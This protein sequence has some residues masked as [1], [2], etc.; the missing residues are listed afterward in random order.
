[1]IS[2]RACIFYATLLLIV[3]ATA[4]AQTPIRIAAQ[5][6]D[7][8]F[9]PLLTAVYREMGFDAQI[10]VLP[11]ARALSAT[12]AGQFDAEVGRIP[13][14]SPS[15]PDLAYTQEPLLKVQLVAVTLKG[16]PIGIQSKADLEK[17][18]VG[19][20]NGMSVSEYYVKKESLTANSVASHEQLAKMLEIGRLDVVLMGTAF[21]QSPVFAVAETKWVIDEFNVFH[22]FHKR[23]RDLI[24][25]FDAQLRRTKQDGRYEQLLTRP[26]SHRV[27]GNA[28]R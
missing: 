6:G 3:G 17:F 9:F 8:R 5:E 7:E 15:Y 2:K 13:N 20:L 28:P 4:H 24:P 18:R 11:S 12:N 16:K 23:N 22:I 14:I 19:Y 10:T 21:K 25:I 26:S 27:H 1:M